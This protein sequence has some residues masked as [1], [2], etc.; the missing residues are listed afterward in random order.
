MYVGIS[1]I[2][3]LSAYSRFEQLNI[4]IDLTWYEAVAV[5][6]TGD[7]YENVVLD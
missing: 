4:K 5:V 2:R 1:E 6:D 7:K 3:M